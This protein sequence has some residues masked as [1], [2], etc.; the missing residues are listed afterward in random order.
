MYHTNVHYETPISVAIN[1][2]GRRRY[3]RIN[4]DGRTCAN[5]L[6]G[7]TVHQEIEIR[8][9]ERGSQQKRGAVSP[10]HNE[11][12]HYKRLRSSYRSTRNRPD[13]TTI[14]QLQASPQL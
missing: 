12:N 2:A 4:W 13:I 7:P 5:A 10:Q 1:T 8:L 11:A 6:G 3:P 14:P 9:P